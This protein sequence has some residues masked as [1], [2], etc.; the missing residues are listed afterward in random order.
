MYTSNNN[1]DNDDDKNGPT[2]LGRCLSGRVIA[3]ITALGSIPSTEN[4]R[5]PIYL[6]HWYPSDLGV[7][8]N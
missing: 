6:P 3:S 2:E 7:L 8:V 1:N 5:C 4:H